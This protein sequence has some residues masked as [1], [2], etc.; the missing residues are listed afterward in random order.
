MILCSDTFDCNCISTA[1]HLQDLLITENKPNQAPITSLTDDVV[2]DFIE[3][4]CG[5]IV[6]ASV[7]IAYDVEAA[8]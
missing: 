4:H 8:H 3:N 1:A 7:A 6:G 5:M 2:A